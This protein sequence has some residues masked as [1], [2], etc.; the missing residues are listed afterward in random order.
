MAAITNDQGQ[1]RITVQVLSLVDGSVREVVAW[2]KADSEQA[3][4][5]E[6]FALAKDERAYRYLCS[7]GILTPT[8][9]PLPAITTQY[10]A[11]EWWAASDLIA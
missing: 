1:I 6:L 7:D 8:D 9:P 5:D 3:A 10:A 4:V 2:I 11:G